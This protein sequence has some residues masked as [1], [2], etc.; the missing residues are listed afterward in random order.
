MQSCDDVRRVVL[1]V[2]L[3]V[4][5][6]SQQFVLAQDVVTVFPGRGSRQDWAKAVRISEEA[7]A[8]FEN[9][10][11][12]HAIAKMQKAISVYAY[13]S[14]LYQ[15]NGDYLFASGDYET[16][17]TQYEK[18]I[19]LD[20]KYFEAYNKLGLVNEKM[21]QLQSAERNFRKALVLQPKNFDATYNLGNLLLQTK[22]Y[23]EAKK[24]LEPA[25]QLANA[26]KKK[27]S[28]ALW[29]VDG[30]LRGANK[31]KPTATAKA[32]T[33]AKSAKPR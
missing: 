2:L 24:V 17:G 19:E 20:P 22:R 3:L 18:A 33:A 4:I 1:C 12:D 28:D 8:L 27:V 16:A 23:V 11:V 14:A 30:A 7:T 13:D 32:G 26:D 6:F 15:K 31:P 10:R 9:K 29:H 21:G 25:A 5:S